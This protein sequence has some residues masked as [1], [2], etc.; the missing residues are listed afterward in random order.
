MQNE[1]IHITRIKRLLERQEALIYRDKN[2]VGALFSTDDRD[3]KPI[4]TGDIWGSVWQT[5]VFKVSGK[6]PENASGKDYGLFFDCD[7]EACVME[8][9][10]PRQGL[11]PKVDW[12]HK[13]AKHYVP[14][15]PKC[16]PGEVFRLVIEASAN[17]LF[18]A[19]KEEYRLRE[20]ALVS[21]DEELFQKTMDI[22]LLL[23][24][25]EALPAGTVRRQRLLYG[26]NQVCNFWNS[27]PGKVKALLAE[28]LSHPA[29]SSALTA[30]SVGHAHLD[31][32]WLWPIR[33]TRRKGGR[34]FANALRLLEQYPAYVFGASQAQLYQWIKEDYPALYEEVKTRVHSGRWEVQGASWVEFD[35]NLISAESIIRQFMYGKR[36]FAAE[37]G[38]A[39]RNLWLPDCF[40]FSG[41][42]PQYLK[43]CGVDW[44]VTQKLSWNESN[45]FPHHLFNWEGID[46]TRILAHQLPTNDY[47]FSNDPSAFLDTEK[48]FAQSELCD[49]FLNLYGIGDGGGGPTRNHI[50]YGLRMRDLEGVCKFRFAKSTDFLE[51]IS[52]LD[53]E[54]LPT[55]YG[56]LYL[57]FHRGTYTTQARMKQDNRTSEKLLGAAEFL[58][59]LAGL[60]EYP[61]SLRSIWQDTLLLQFHDIIP[62]SSIG[63]VYEEAHAI[64]ARNHGLLRDIMNTTARQIPVDEDGSGS[65][66]YLVFNPCNQELE[67]WL[68][69]SEEQKDL[70]PV[71][72]NGSILPFLKADLSLLVQVSV[73]AW[74]CKQVRF[75][76]ENHSPLA[77][78]KT[79]SLTLE[80]E[81]LK[82]VVSE[83]G[84]IS[85]IIEKERG[86]EVLAGESN[87]LLLWEDEPNN[88]GAWDI[89]HFYHETEPQK[90]TQVNLNKELCM[91]LEGQF[92]RIVQDFVI[93]ESTLRQSIELRHGEPFIRVSHE[94][95]WKEKHKMLRTHW[96]PD[97]HNGTA[98]YGIQGGVLKRSCK[99]KNA[100]EE[101]QF[102][103]PA[104][105]FADLSQPD[106]GCALL[107]DVKY[108]Y[109]VRDNEMELNL[110]RSPADVDPA[111]DIHFHSY[112]Y[113]F[114]PHLGDYEHSDVYS[115]AE[116]LAN[117]LVSIPLSGKL[118]KAPEVP[119]RL[120]SDH[121]NI[122]TIKPVEKG[123]GTVLR[124]HEYKG[125]SGIARLFCSRAYTDVI[126]C[127]MLEEPATTLASHLRSQAMVELSFRP[128]ETKTLLLKEES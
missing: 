76:K 93:G 46:G 63:M 83:N 77:P 119:F 2:P 94:I 123:S 43:G 6:I 125:Q 56:E 103:V 117:A 18:G 90:A 92:S 105:R 9:G 60:K 62:G 30:F 115:Q 69:F 51:H 86:R 116:K 33:E 128:F 45:V 100:W 48:R 8:K 65:S 26:L 87:L 42:L 17:D 85:S 81:Y 104:Q 120:E 88:W 102:E 13:A 127:D 78:L 58:A 10:T 27:D 106:R 122:D 113:A 28:M 16:K 67:D 82:V 96:Q 47:N 14:L 21:F 74:G 40:G 64:S 91:T 61:P 73:P 99:P 72:D 23:N 95:D 19:G 3:F 101:A 110:L 121:I 25:A 126:E 1:K 109:R 89:N 114:Y 118:Q 68:A 4:Q 55:V 52:R 59:V 39:P 57:E 80:N 54:T 107:C 34:T 53:L 75:V 112:T 111:A 79:D 29:H 15:S 41:N 49:T 31:L 5:G 84:G 24:L 32:A 108:G 22:G 124:F 36:F 7:G 70:V 66:Y 98:T 12:Y 11:T 38:D 50:E 71:D 20:C 44:F 35:T 37:F 97:I